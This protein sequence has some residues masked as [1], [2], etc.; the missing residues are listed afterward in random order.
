MH[1]VYFILEWH[2]TCFWWSFNHQE[3][4]TAHTA[5]GICQTDTAVCLLAGTRWNCSISYLLPITVFSH[6]RLW[7]TKDCVSPPQISHD[8]EW[9]KTVFPHHRYNAVHFTTET[10][11]HLVNKNTSCKQDA[12]SNPGYNLSAWPDLLVSGFSISNS[13]SLYNFVSK[14][15]GFWRQLFLVAATHNSLSALIF[16]RCIGSKTEHGPQL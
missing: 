3:F 5:T 9:Q 4:K 10:E 16:V 8:C 11:S 15:A 12:I 6:S 14:D 2:S 13:W 1:Q 7:V